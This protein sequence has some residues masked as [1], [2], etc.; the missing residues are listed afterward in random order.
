MGYAPDLE[1]VLKNVNFYVRHCEHI[2]IVGRNGSGKLYLVLA[3][4]RFLE[5]RNGVIEIDGVDISQ[6][7]LHDLPVA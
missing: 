6:I 1:S 3:L 4:F 5:A 2:G 7:N